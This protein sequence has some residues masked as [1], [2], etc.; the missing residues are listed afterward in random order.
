MVMLPTRD[1]HHFVAVTS[2]RLWTS[3]AMVGVGVDG[4]TK[5][6]YGVR[7]LGL[8]ARL[9][10]RRVHLG[11]WDNDVEFLGIS[12]MVVAK[13]EQRD[14]RDGNGSS[15][16]IQQTCTVMTWWV[17][18]TRRIDS[19]VEFWRAAQCVFADRLRSRGRV[20]LSTYVGRSLA[21]RRLVKPGWLSSICLHHTPVYNGKLKKM[22]LP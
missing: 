17:R 11:R 3:V 15:R 5:T 8:G 20:L 9:M 7:G 13:E 10:T 2:I 14:K 19:A 1:T 12:G 16:R 18:V 21:D 4:D 6:C 22:G